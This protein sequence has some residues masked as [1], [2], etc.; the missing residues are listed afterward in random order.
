MISALPVETIESEERVPVFLLI[1]CSAVYAF[2]AVLAPF[3]LGGVSEREEFQLFV[4]AWLAVPPASL[5]AALV[6]R[7]LARGCDRDPGVACG[8]LV[9]ANAAFAYGAV[10]GVATGRLAPWQA[11]LAAPAFN[12][13]ALAGLRR[14]GARWA[15]G[16]GWFSGSRYLLVAVP[17][18][19]LLAFL[20]F[21]LPQLPPGQWPVL[22]LV[23]VLALLLHRSR[24]GASR[25]REAG[26]RRFAW[27]ALVIAVVALLCYD[28]RYCLDMHHHNFYLG[29]VSELRAGR[30]LLVDVNCQYGVFVIYVLS[31]LLRLAALPVAPRA[32]AFLSDALLAAQ[33]AA[34]YLLLKRCLRWRPAALAL[35]GVGL[36]VVTNYFGPMGM[37]GMYPS[38][39][40]LRFGLPY[41]LMAAVVLRERF[42]AFRRAGLAL[43]ASV[44]GVA[45]IWSFET[46]V[47]TAATYG[48]LVVYESFAAS[49]GARAFLASA[50]KRA[51]AALAASGLAHA[52]LAVQIFAR[53]GEWPHW[54]RYLDYVFLYAGGFG[55]LPVDPAS[56][57]GL[58]VALQLG[59][60]LLIAY[61][62]LVL[63]ER[64]EPEWN[65][66]LAMAAFSIAQFTYFLGRSHWNNL[67]HVAIAPIFLAVYW[68]DWLSRPQ[69]RLPSQLLAP[70]QYLAYFGFCVLL[71]SSFPEFADKVR[72]T[73]AYAVVESA[74]GRP[75]DLLD[76][77]KNAWRAT[78]RSPETAEAAYL[79]EALA[80]GQARVPVIIAPDQ[81]LEALRLTGRANLFPMGNPWQDRLSPPAVERIVSFPHGL[82]PG[83]LVFLDKNVGRLLVIQG[84]LLHRLCG[85][86]AFKTVASTPTGMVAVRLEAPRGACPEKDWRTL[87][88]LL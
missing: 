15:D 8:A 74:A 87:D 5:A 2:L 88:R 3:A 4:L 60:V 83:D 84:R 67:Y 29:P 61:K 57:W 63:G 85:E 36:V 51:G 77:V 21:G 22:F 50:A 65:V 81:Q 40:P 31:L 33:Y 18:A 39:G 23:S 54:E 27:D 10:L 82:K 71:W 17:A 34:V 47:Y 38:T 42:P 76:R 59:T 35:L 7:R 53:S 45:S 72:V 13:L 14:F 58:I 56:P 79:I 20:G 70:L 26:R 1:A 37:P 6:L 41:A 86:F 24:G 62:L 28:T 11:A 80:P 44:L 30:S 55:A 68:L 32:L 12:A 73:A 46:W 16:R 19:G 69:R 48:A 64:G 78:P 9:A 49:A 43:E 52:V 25:P 66:V 75:V